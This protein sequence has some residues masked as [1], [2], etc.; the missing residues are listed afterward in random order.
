MAV[1]IRT[2]KKRTWLALT[3]HSVAEKLGCEFVTFLGHPGSQMDMPDAWVT[4]LRS[5]LH[6]A[7]EYSSVNGKVSWDRK[8]SRTSESHIST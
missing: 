4:T 1:G 7:G 6:K 3:S 8:Y 2:L 5:V